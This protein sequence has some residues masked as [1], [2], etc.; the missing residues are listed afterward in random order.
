MLTESYVK[1]PELPITRDITIGQL[2][3][4]VAEEH[5]NR[6]ALIAGV[7]ELGNRRECSYGELYADSLIAAQIGRAVQQE[8]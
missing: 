5:P 3:K 1:G 7:S 4:E 2:L 8:C 6:L